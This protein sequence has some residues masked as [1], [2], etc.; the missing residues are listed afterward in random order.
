[1][2]GKH[3]GYARVSTNEQNLERQMQLL[4]EAGCEKIFT[5]KDSGRQ[6]KRKGWEEAK[7]F[8]REEDTLFIHDL[9]RLGRSM[10]GIKQEWE[11]LT[12]MKVHI[13]VLNMPILDTRKYGEME[14][15][16]QMVMN[17]LKEVF[18]WMAEEQWKQ[19]KEA[20]DQ[21]IAIAKAQGKYKGR[22]TEFSPEGKH[23][24]KYYMILN[25]LE[26]GYGQ[27]EIA[28]RMNCGLSTVKRIKKR[29]RL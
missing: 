8:L 13:V 6:M 22:Q 26:Q 4:R 1:M 21:G 18:A 24:D 17:L 29:K 15:V 19:R 23:R 25:L 9:N 12:K 11:V 27:Q 7:A 28:K 3:I 20:Q 5:D 16:G 14:I 10:E 2:A